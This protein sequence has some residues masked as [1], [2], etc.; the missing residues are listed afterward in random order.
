[1]RALYHALPACWMAVLTL[2]ALG[3]SFS[4]RA[5][6]EGGGQRPVRAAVLKD[7]LPGLDAALVAELSEALQS[8]GYQAVCV[9][10]QA[11]SDAT[12]LTREQF[13]MLVLP[14]AR[15]LP[16][17]TINPI[18]EFLKAG[19]NLIALGLPAWGEPALR[20]NDKW[21]T[22]AEYDAELAG[23]RA[24]A[25]II[26]FANEDL[27]NW[28]R[29]TNQHEPP[30]TYA[31]EADGEA[32][33]KVLHVTIPNLTG[34]E[35]YGRNV[36][37]PFAAGQTLTCFRAK[38]T[39]RTQQLALEWT[40]KDGSRWIATVDLK[41]EWQ[42]YALP[43]QAF[44]A[45]QPP[46]ARSGAG[47]CL[48]VENAGR[49]T[50]GVAL[51]H[52]N[53]G[54]GAHEYWFAD[55]G[56]AKNP[57]GAIAPVNVAVPH[58]DGLSPGYQFY[59]LAGPVRQLSLRSFREPHEAEPPVDLL[60]LHP[61]PGG[62]GF[63]KDR[64][65]RWQPLLEAC[66]GPPG[67]DH[68]G[69]LAALVVN[70]KGPYRGSAIGAFAPADGAF[71]RQPAIRDTIEDTAKAMRVGVFLLE[72][73]SEHYT[74]REGD[75]IPLGATVIATRT[76]PP[77]LSVQMWIGV[78]N[79]SRNECI[80]S[81][82]VTLEAGKTVAIEEAWKPAERER[83]RDGYTTLT[84]LM[85]D[86][87]QLGGLYGNIDD[88]VRVFR[89]PVKPEFVTVR[90]GHFWLKG[91][92]WRAHGVNY[93]PSSGI[94]VADSEVFEYWLDKA[95]Y[96][97]EIIERDLRRIKALDLNAVSA[98]V[99]H[100]SLKSG[101]LLDFLRRCEVLGLK[102]NLSLRPGTPLDF[103]W[104]EMKEIIEQYDL[105]KNDTVFAYDLAWEPSHYD[106]A[107]QAKT[108]TKAWIQ[109]VENKYGAI[110]DAIKAWG[111]DGPRDG[112]GVLTVPPMQHLT[113]DGPWRKL[114]ADYRAFLD[115][116]L[117]QKYAAARRLIR[118]VDPN[119]L[120][121]FRMQLSGDP[122]HNDDGLLPYDFY[123][124]RNAV[125][126]WEPEAYGRIGDWEK[127][128]PGEF[129][130]AYAR[131]C[132]PS[133]PLVWAEMGTS[134]WNNSRMAPDP[135]ALDFEAQYYRDFYRMMRQS[136]ADGIFYWW[137]PGGYRVGEKSDYG[138]INPD[139]TDR[140]VT[141]V[142]REEAA[143]F[144]NAPPPPQPDTWISVDRNRDARG[145]HGIY[146]Q[147]KDA[148]WRAR[149]EGKTAGLKWEKEP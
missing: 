95:A 25:R 98:F 35:T 66:S 9:D 137:Y 147:A 120:V 107:Y 26:A 43:P 73:G 101:N 80:K 11:L 37:E 103:R 12:K 69:A 139:G 44:I 134:V 144:L 126:I 122:T 149:A 56:A 125:D 49:F 79:T 119:H 29:G 68:R 40:E 10:L 109:W 86:V 106:H 81:W 133:L 132:N 105:A 130:A 90:D 32:I 138:I 6:A 127:V 5:A 70:A 64:A 61:R 31:I 67:Y 121:S 65:W 3:V 143:A 21:M 18:Q 78:A 60:A 24:Q 94:G 54:G 85:T 17:Q 1:M 91:Q 136:G 112:K 50:V 72:G 104:N 82:P 108:Y 146:E 74:V 115:Q 47:D 99:Y 55:L 22:K 41:P 27:K 36:T 51:T 39:Q 84:R 118:T 88:E 30:A 83:V 33:Q 116:L 145:L 46:A 75:S 102:V 114:A 129:T 123:G 148:Y 19:G 93:M 142:I 16:L 100:R 111:V 71:Y 20:V 7:N 53:I 124:L 57:L 48:R 42:W 63:Q 62:A 13:D 28:Q 96:D 113:Q 97:P 92:L 110:E 89:P 135:K 76:P 23:Q 52:T 140:P 131:L 34:W 58:I 128:K 87:T 4:L 14:H 141:Q 117:G 2:A 45:W 59:T 38:G 15:T 8:A 77:G